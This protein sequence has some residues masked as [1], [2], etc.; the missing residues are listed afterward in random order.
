MKGKHF[1]WLIA[2]L[3]LIGFAVIAFN[4]ER[5]TALDSAVYGVVSG[6]I[7]PGATAFFVGCTSLVGPI[8]L[9]IVSFTLVIFLPRKE[10]RIPLLV[11][12]SAAILLNIGL[13]HVF[14][15]ARPVDVVHI[16]TETG[17]SFPSGHSMAATCFY[18]FLIYLVWR[19]CTNKALRAAVVALLSAVI[20]LVCLSRVYLGVHYFSD[21]LAGMLLSVCYLVLFTS[22]VNAFF[23]LEEE[24]KPKG[25]RPNGHNQLI[26]SFFYAFQGVASG[27]KSERNMVIHFAMI[28]AVVVFGAMLDISQSEWIACVILF[29]VVIM[30]ELMNTAVETVVDI[31]CPRYDPRAKLAKDT[32]AGA[33]LLAAVAAAIV[34][35]IIFVPKLLDLVAN[36]L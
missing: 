31:V 20:A 33:V 32:A 19:L 13:K 11:N 25:I 36:E 7:S 8:L 14:T 3:C 18:G 17:Y 5:M 21:V 34:G 4:L 23:T 27:L 2:A 30:A 16:A 10:Y 6:W 35:L 9:L 15:R 29:G 22:L 24:N 26:F 1:K 12:L 28:A